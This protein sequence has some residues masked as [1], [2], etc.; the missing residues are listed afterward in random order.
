MWKFWEDSDDEKLHINT[1]MLQLKQSL[2]T[3]NLKCLFQKRIKLK[4]S[5]A[6]TFKK[7]E[8]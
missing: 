5:K 4:I 6:F 7:L 1:C 2:E 8:K 3:H